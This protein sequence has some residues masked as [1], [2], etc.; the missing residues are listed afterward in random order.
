MSE[1]EAKDDGGVAPVSTVAWRFVRHRDSVRGGRV[2]EGA[3]RA[4]QGIAGCGADRRRRHRRIQRSGAGNRKGLA[5]PVART[6]SAAGQPSVGASNPAR[7]SWGEGRGGRA[8]LIALFRRPPTPLRVVP[9]G[10]MIQDGAMARHA[11]GESA[12]RELK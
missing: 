1:T 3:I 2:A 7:R 10:L 8:D 9:A 5:Q 12:G 11:V 4:D 6:A